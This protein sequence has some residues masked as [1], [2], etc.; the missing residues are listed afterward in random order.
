MRSL[1]PGLLAVLLALSACASRPDITT[2]YDHNANFSLYRSFAFEPKLG[3]EAAGYTSLTTQRIKT[4]IEREMT[5][6]RYVYDEADPD[7]L[8]N[9][10]AKLE[11][12][13]NVT[14][15]PVPMSYYYGYYG[16]R[17]GLYAPWPGYALDTNVDH[18]TEG[19]INIDLIDRQRRQMVWEGVAVG[20][21]SDK[22]KQI[23][24]E[25]INRTVSEI[26]AKY[27]FRPG[28]AAAQ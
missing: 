20:R 4:A 12:K 8:V 3:T 19:T 13:V 7:L 14:Q 21:I 24:E 2:D 16:Y 27:P 9:F 11:D 18:Y 23:P 25:D 28:G 17:A 22:M 1:V 6:R 15:T 5:A 26:F 10:S